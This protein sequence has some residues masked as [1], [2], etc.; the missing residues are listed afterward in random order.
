M[1]VTTKYVFN[2]V[3]GEVLEH[4]WY[5]Y[6][7]AV[8]LCKGDDTVKAQEQLNYQ[9]SQQQMAFNGQMMDLFKTQFAK[10][11]AISQY[12]QGVLKP[13]ID[14]P[15]GYSPTALSSMKAQATDTLTNQY[16]NVRKAAQTQQFAQGGR[17]LPSG[18]NAQINAGILQG[19]ASDTAGALNGI[20]LQNENLKQANFWNAISGLTGQ[21]SL[22]NPLGYAG[23]ANQGSGT[24]ASLGNSG[25]ALSQAYTASQSSGLLGTVLGGAF[26]LGGALLGNPSLF[27]GKGA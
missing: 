12:L 22:I 5:E 8:E 10:Q 21:Q 17:D 15:Q 26:G 20:N 7:G 16:E 2:I 27:K 13:M 4:E 6:A 24:V 25:A 14:N 3:T 9:Q 23:A 1:R 19:Q 18:V 11:D